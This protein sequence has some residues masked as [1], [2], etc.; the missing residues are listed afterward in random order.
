[1]TLSI[2]RYSHVVLSISSTL[3]LI[4]AAVTGVILAFEPISNSLQPYVIK[5]LDEVTIDTTILILQ[6]T[7]AEVLELEVLSSDCVTASVITKEGDGKQIYINPLTGESLGDVIV[8]T[9]IYRWTTN[10]HRSLFLKNTGRIFMGITSFLLCLIAV[11]GL[12]LLIKRQGSIFKLYTK[13]REVDFAQ[14]Y[15]VQLGRWLLLPIIIIATTGV[16]L[17]AEKFSLV[18]QSSISHNWN[19]ISINSF[20]ENNIDAFKILE[21]IQLS[22]VQKLIF[23]FSKDSEDYYQLLLKDRELLV[24]QYTGE[25]ISEVAYPFVKIASRWS[26]QLHTGQGNIIWALILLIASASILFFIYS[27]FLM[28]LRRLKQSKRIISKINKDDCEYIILVGSETGSTYAFAN[29]FYKALISIGKKVNMSSLNGYTT[30]KKGKHL[31]VFTAT[32]GDGDAPSNARNFEILFNSVKP[33]NKM[34]FSVV[35]FGELSYTHYCRYAIILDALLQGNSN[36][37]PILPLGKVNE[38]STRSFKNWSNKWSKKAGVS[39]EIYLK[40]THKKKIKEHQFKIKKRTSL[41]ADDTFLLTVEP[42]KKL[43]FQSGDLIGVLPINEKK[44]RLYSIAKLDNQVLLSIKKHEKGICSSYLSTLKP[45]NQLKGFITKNRAFH[46]PKKASSILLISNGTGIA[47][48]LGMITENKDNI[49]IHLF[50]GGRTK[51]SYELYRNK[52][53]RALLCRQ[54]KTFNVAYSQEHTKQYVQ[55]VLAK[56]T[57]LVAETLKEGGKVMICGSLVMQHGVLNV[58][59]TISIK[60]LQKKISDFENNEQLVMDCY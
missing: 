16:Y 23:P 15:H 53:E 45:G 2:W 34:Q 35:G 32:Y 11:T 48:F 26:M 20:N 33:I 47:P 42:I 5:N 36:F 40:N 46:F 3:F 60:E 50:W 38:K 29:A 28:T 1:M 9:P 59:E 31:I 43:K 8:R 19:E 37:T 14:H 22:N 51:A 17:S 49:P 4:I 56:N 10:L 13:I 18:P 24:H 57:S 58:L 39:L 7:Y 44:E 12:L 52:I 30:Y 27:G 55:D 21:K 25:V 54:I 41:N 6:E